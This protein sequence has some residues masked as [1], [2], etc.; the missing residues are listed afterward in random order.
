MA[1]S[2][3]IVMTIKRKPDNIENVFAIKFIAS[4]LFETYGPNS[5]LAMHDIMI[6]K[7]A[8]RIKIIS[9]IFSQSFQIVNF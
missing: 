9:N 2:P 4:L 1:N 6:I 5:K 3:D 7:T 8:F